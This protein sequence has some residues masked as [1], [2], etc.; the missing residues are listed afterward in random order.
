MSTPP[1]SP[2]STSSS[3]KPLTADRKRP[4]S[5]LDQAIVDAAQ[6]QYPAP[7]V[8]AKVVT[9]T[10]VFRSKIGKKIFKLCAPERRFR[11][12]HCHGLSPVHQ[13]GVS[14]SVAEPQQKKQKV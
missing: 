4:R 2:A 11:V 12:D 8:R 10:T 13:Q 1:S 5:C 9:K 7:K 3:P 6:A 14:Q